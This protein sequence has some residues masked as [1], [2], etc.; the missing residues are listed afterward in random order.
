[1]KKLSMK[2]II[3]LLMTVIM[4]FAISG[5]ALATSPELDNTKIAP[6]ELE[7]PVDLQ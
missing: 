6:V 4:V 2:R 1:M 3:S 5:S 7:L